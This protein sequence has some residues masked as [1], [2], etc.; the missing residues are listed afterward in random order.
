M[1]DANAWGRAEQYERYMG[2][3][4]RKLAPLFLQWMDCQPGLRW[5]DVGCGTGALSAAILER[6]APRSVTGVEPADGFLRVARSALGERVTLLPGSATSIP[7]PDGAVDAVVSSL[8]LNF[9]D[10]QPAARAEMARV[11]GAGG[12]LGVMVWDYSG[13]MEFIQYFWRAAAQV[14][15]QA[16]ALDEGARFPI[17]HADALHEFFT[18]AGFREVRVTGLEIETVFTDFD[19][20]W[21]PFL[22]GQGVCPAYLMG[23]DADTREALRRSV[24]AMLPAQPDGSIRL[25]AR[26]WAAHAQVP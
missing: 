16:V 25:V 19:D 22:G 17:C 18:G 20:Y 11:A 24:Q 26:A 7:L 10:D 6:C 1:T 3:W 8:V 12:T 13:K 15:P 2:R 23:L 5:L 9:V 21:G 4:S 14:D